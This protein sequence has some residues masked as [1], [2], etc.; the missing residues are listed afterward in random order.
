MTCVDGR[1]CGVVEAEKHGATLTGVEI[2]S[3]RYAQ[4]LPA[5]LAARRW[6][7]PFMYEPNDIETQFTQGLDPGPRARNDFAFHQPALLADWLN[8]LPLATTLSTGAAALLF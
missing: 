4:G 7:L 1:A 2:Q 3:A 6:L 5:S 8:Q